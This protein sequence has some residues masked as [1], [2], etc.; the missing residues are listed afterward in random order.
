M[1][2]TIK[3]KSERAPAA[4]KGGSGGNTGSDAISVTVN[5]VRLE[6]SAELKAA[7]LRAHQ[8]SQQSLPAE[9]TTSQAAEFLDVSRPFVIKLTEQGELPCRLVGKHRRIPTEALV[10][11]RERMFQQARH[12]A[13][14]ISQLA[15]EAGLYDKERA[16]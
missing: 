14:E 6:L 9:M 11:H 5:G 10:A 15:Q 13:D 12:A 3:K 7:V 2:R 1:S 8:N 4:A 16:G